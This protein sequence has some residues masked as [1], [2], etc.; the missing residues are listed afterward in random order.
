MLESL[1]K[2][3]E[4]TFTQFTMGRL[5]YVIFIIAILSSSIY[6]YNE[7]T[8]YSH[9][10]HIDHKITALERL[11]SL[12]QKGIKNSEELL[13]VYKNVISELKYKEKTTSILSQHSE[14]ITKIISAT[15]LM[16]L[17]VI[18]GA[19]G[20]LQGKE[21]S[22]SVFFGA[23]FFTILMAVPAWFV[24]LVWESLLITSGFLFSVQIAL[25]LFITKKYGD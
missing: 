16:I 6:L 3:I 20:M 19:I 8:G 5:F 18:Y 25:L 4:S 13:S 14:G 17:F 9:Y 11:Y 12:E 22:S 21:E 7:T 2:S 15:V 10:S 24:P 23:L 1:V